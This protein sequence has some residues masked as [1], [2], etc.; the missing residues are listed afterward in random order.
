M[1]NQNNKT[2]DII[3]TLRSEVRIEDVAVKYFIV[4]AHEYLSNNNLIEKGKCNYQSRINIEVPTELK[5]DLLKLLDGLT[6]DE[7]R[8]IIKDLLNDISFSYRWSYGGSTSQLG[9]LAY[10]LLKLNEGRGEILYIPCSGVGYPLIPIVEA[11]K[12]DKIHFKDIICNDISAEACYLQSLLIDIFYEDKE[13]I[14]VRCGDMFESTNCYTTTILY[15]L[16]GHR[17]N[18]EKIEKKF[19][20]IFEDIPYE[21]LINSEWIFVDKI[22]ANRYKSCFRGLVLVSAKTLWEERSSEYRKRII[23]NGYLE[24]IIELPTKSLTNT[25]IPT[26]LLV[27]SEGNKEV[28]FL[29]ASQML[30]KNKNRFSERERISNLDL[31]SILE[32]YH[33]K[34]NRLSIDEAK[35]LKNLT[36]SIVSAKKYDLENATRLGDIAEVF[37]GNQYTLTNFKGMIEEAETG[38][39]I[40]TSNDVTDYLINYDSLTHI[41]YEDTKFDKYCLKYGDVVVTSKSSKA[42][43]GV[44]DF[45]P[46]EKIIVTGGMIIVR[47]NAKK[48]NPTYLKLFL[49]SEAGQSAIKAIQKGT[50][51]IS[52][53]SKDLAEVKIP[54]VDIKKQNKAAIKFNRTVSNIIACKKELDKLENSLNDILNNE[55]EDD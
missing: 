37:S 49:D 31:G 1:L 32:K 41:K 3:N 33:D 40:L 44:V 43:V 9:E 45:E 22:L 24:G 47:P 19:S 39:S 29:D 5:D 13:P 12:R 35:N 4:T 27:L 30:I 46:K 54:L 55:E 34:F 50:V 52:L 48:L 8:K 2:N 53:A 7:I 15:G 26:Y 18:K 42:K 36:P 21:S 25:M 14:F 11:A 16:L 51:I 17:Y 20:S 28:K 10:R 38:T 23:E 6:L